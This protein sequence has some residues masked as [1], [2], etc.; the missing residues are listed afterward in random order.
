MVDR[1]ILFNRKFSSSKELK[2]NNYNNIT[3]TDE[4]KED[5]SQKQSNNNDKNDKI[6][7]YTRI[8]I[9]N[10]FNNRKVILK[11]AKGQKGVSYSSVFT[12]TP[13]CNLNPN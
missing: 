4:N 12:E 7:K 1:R 11:V 6:P 5:A 8:F 2:F 10:P 3:I 13:S 9:E